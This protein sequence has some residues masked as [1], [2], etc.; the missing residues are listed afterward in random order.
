MGGAGCVC[1][2]LAGGVI[3]L[4][5]FL[6]RDRPG[7]PGAAKIAALSRELHD[8]FKQA[9]GPPCC[10]VLSRKDKGKGKID[11]DRCRASTGLGAQLAAEIIIREQPKVLKNLNLDFL[12]KRDGKLTS[13]L[14]KAR[15]LLRGKE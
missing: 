3:A 1:G 9:L 4:G 11:L 7:G 13:T 2:S 6:G 10:R 14:L 12:S 8:K 5:L 15:E